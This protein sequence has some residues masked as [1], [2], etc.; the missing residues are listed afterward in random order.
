[1]VLLCLSEESDRGLPSSKADVRDVADN[2]I[3]ERRDDAVGKN[4]VDRFIHR[5]PELRVPW[6]R[7]YDHQRAVCGDPAVVQSWST[8][9]Q[10]MKAKHSIV[11]KDTYDFDKFGFLTGRISSQLVGPGS[12]KPGW[13]AVETPTHRS[14][15]DYAGKTRRV[16]RESRLPRS[17][18]VPVGP[19]EILTS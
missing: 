8:L 1:V 19:Q 10:S 16:D 3:R 17:V 6:T 2:L 13:E 5:T 18:D 9:V 12:E 4:W 14:R 7:P 11:D 15:V